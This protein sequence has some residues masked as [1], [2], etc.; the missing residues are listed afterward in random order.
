MGHAMSPFTVVTLEALYF[1]ELSRQC[2]KKK[3]PVLSMAKAKYVFHWPGSPKFERDSEWV[4][5][6]QAFFDHPR[7]T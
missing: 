6:D 4:S 5:T 7:S 3:K 1:T 2:T